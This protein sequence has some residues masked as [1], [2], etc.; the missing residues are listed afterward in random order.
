MSLISSG[1]SNVRVLKIATGIAGDGRSLVEPGSFGITWKSSNVGKL[2]QVYVNGELAGITSQ[3]QEREIIVP[4]KANYKGN[5][6]V[7][8]FAVD[9]KNVFDDFSEEIND[10]MTNGRV[11]LNFVRLASLPC[12]GSFN[13]YSNDGCGEIN[14]AKAVNTSCIPL[15]ASC[16]DKTGFGMGS[17]GKD[18]F[19]YGF[20]AALG[21][22]MGNFGCGEFGADADVVVWQSAELNSGCYRYAVKVQNELGIESEA[23]E[24]GGE[25]VV[26]AA[27]A[28]A[29]GLS[30]VSFDKQTNKLVL[31]IS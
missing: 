10:A 9:I 19:G 30:P 31:R 14:F 20:A 7:H 24:A 22:G 2:H 21:F 6:S 16:C 17:F 12:L 11:Q 25:I 5:I 1:I 4:G 29:E 23:L 18:D 3:E 8:V 28:R 13:V 27:E 15:L 26:I